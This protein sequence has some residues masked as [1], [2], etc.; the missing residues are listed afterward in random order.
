MSD[1]E[2]ECAARTESSPD[3]LLIVI[4]LRHRT[5]R[6]LK[7]SVW[8]L[9]QLPRQKGL[10]AIRSASPAYKPKPTI[11]AM[12]TFPLFISSIRL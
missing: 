1:F 4:N 12:P 11:L 8:N 2:V 7:L 9:R 5:R 3:P 6:L 10:N